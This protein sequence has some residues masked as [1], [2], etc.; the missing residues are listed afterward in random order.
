MVLDGGGARSF[1]VL[2]LP[3]NTLTLR[4]LVL[5]NGMASASPQE[6]GAVLVAA[7]SL[8]LDGCRSQA[9]HRALP[10]VPCTLPLRN[11]A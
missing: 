11:T 3:S 8:I 7:G 4:G 9:A 5:R 6:G 1:F 2:S 10:H